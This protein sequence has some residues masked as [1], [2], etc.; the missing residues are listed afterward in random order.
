MEASRCQTQICACSTSHA[1][2]YVYSAIRPL[3]KTSCRELTDFQDGITIQQED[4]YTRI[5]TVFLCYQTQR[6]YFSFIG[7]NTSSFLHRHQR[8]FLKRPSTC[9]YSKLLCIPSIALSRMSFHFVFNLFYS[10]LY[11]YFIR[12]EFLN[13]IRVGIEC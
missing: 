2:L 10:Q 5:P 1:A 13:T 8:L 12:S 6:I 11:Y 7:W 3:E 4:H 9:V